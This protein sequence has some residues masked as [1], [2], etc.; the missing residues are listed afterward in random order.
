MPSDFQLEKFLPWQS[1]YFDVAGQRMHYFDVSEAGQDKP[2]AVLLHGN[3]TWS[4]Y[5]RNLITALKSEFRVIAPDFIGMGL[6]DHPEHVHFKGVDRIAHLE[7]LISHLG[8]SNFSLV[9]HD[10]GGPIGTGYAVRHPDSIDKLVY[11]NTTLTET[12]NLPAIIKRAASPL[13][14]KFLTK[15][16]RSFLELTVDLGARKKVSPEVRA[17]YF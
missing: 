15:Y 1:H 13:T 2:A 10:W 5:Y 4:F 16:S 14:G 17:G 8:I 6:S 12:D 7:A 9:M 3:P 11:L